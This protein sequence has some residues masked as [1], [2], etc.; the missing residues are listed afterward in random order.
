MGRWIL[1]KLTTIFVISAKAR[2]VIIFNHKYLQLKRR[3]GHRN[4]VFIVENMELDMTQDIFVLR[5]ILLCVKAPVFPSII[6]VNSIIIID[7]NCY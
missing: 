1:I 5:V 4:R 7:G 2:L 3:N 6:R